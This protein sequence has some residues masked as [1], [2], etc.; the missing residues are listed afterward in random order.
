M[1]AASVS[2]AAQH[3]QPSLSD[4]STVDG[5]ARPN[6]SAS[7]LV[8]P[9]STPHTTNE[10]EAK[11]QPLVGHIDGSVT[12]P[13]DSSSPLR[14]TNA[15]AVPPPPHTIASTR[16]LPLSPADF[17]ENDAWD[18]VVDVYPRAYMQMQIL[19]EQ[20]AALPQSRVLEETRL[21]RD[22]LVEEATLRLAQAEEKG[23]RDVAEQEEKLE[24]VPDY[25]LM[26]ATERLFAR[27]R[28]ALTGANGARPPPGTSGAA[29]SLSVAPHGTSS[30][31][32]S[33]HSAAPGA[34]APPPVLPDGHA[35][36]ITPLGPLSPSTETE[37]AQ[38]GASPPPPHIPVKPRE[39]ESSENND[40]G[41]QKGGQQDEQ[42]EDTEER[43]DD[44]SGSHI[45]SSVHEALSLAERHRLHH[46]VEYI[47]KSKKNLR[48]CVFHKKDRR[49][50]LCK[51]EPQN[52]VR[53]DSGKATLSD[54]REMDKAMSN[55]QDQSES[56]AQSD[57]RGA[58]EKRHHD[59]TSENDD[60]DNDVDRA[61]RPASSK[62]QK[63]ASSST[64][65]T[66]RNGRQSSGSK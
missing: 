49:I 21:R 30:T 52:C 27:C 10:S 38:M 48:V 60:D 32:S 29:R 44:D 4:H 64:P 63:T 65:V 39:T 54:L 62:Q 57:H 17:S 58:A 61:Q 6:D 33:S 47:R 5:T 41:E 56:K 50:G 24:A 37:R 40:E 26:R 14:S 35:T 2:L 51:K 20:V 28:D 45:F 7:S 15:N 16:P 66:A 55:R 42:E 36:V 43:D 9:H 31:S 18:V 23:A 8:S 12:A 34:T 25:Q 19:N 1:S 13:D 22:K 46:V 53:W 11:Q 59:S 3:V